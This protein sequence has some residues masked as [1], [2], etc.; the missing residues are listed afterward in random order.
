MINGIKNNQAAGTE[1]LNSEG[2]KYG[3]KDIKSE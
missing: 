3:G 1:L 2:F